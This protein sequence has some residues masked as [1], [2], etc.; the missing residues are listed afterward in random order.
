MSL[1]SA[2]SFDEAVDN[3][4]PVF[5]AATCAMAR[6][7]RLMIAEGSRS[8]LSFDLARLRCSANMWS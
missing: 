6:S 1:L 2:W 3:N 4:A 7:Y 8:R 5:A